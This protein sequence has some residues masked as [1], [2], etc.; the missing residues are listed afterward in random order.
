MAR[1]IKAGDTVM[2]VTGA[3]KGKTGRVLRVITDKNRVV[4]EGINRVWKHVRPNQRNPQGGRIQKDAPVHLSNVM[5]LDPTTGKGT[6]V[7]FEARD[8]KKHRVAVKSGTDLGVT[9]KA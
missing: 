2:V 8:G 4:I 1:H 7:K 5:P 9:G 3:D 6:R